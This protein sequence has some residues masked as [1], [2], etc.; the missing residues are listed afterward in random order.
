MKIIVDAMGGDNAPQ[1]IVEGALNAAR[2]LD[3]EITLVGRTE[4]VLKAVEA[5]DSTYPSTP[6]ICPAKEMRGSAFRR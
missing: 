5:A 4:A 2:D 1:A 3:V 6:V